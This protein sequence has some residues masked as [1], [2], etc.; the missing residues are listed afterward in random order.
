MSTKNKGEFLID[1]LDE[2][3]L[4]YLYKN[5]LTFDWKNQLLLIALIGE[6]RNNDTYTIFTTISRLHPRLKDILGNVTL[7]HFQISN[8]MFIYINI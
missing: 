7:L 6:V 8:Q 5:C 2:R 4:K 3:V 1:K